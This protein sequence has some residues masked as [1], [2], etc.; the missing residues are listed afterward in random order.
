MENG[1][2]N[3]SAECR[4]LTDNNAY[5]NF[6]QQKPGRSFSLKFRYFIQ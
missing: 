1:K 5:D 4:N 2:Y 3:L 6:R